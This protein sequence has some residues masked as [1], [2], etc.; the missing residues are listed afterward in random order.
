M[1]PALYDILTYNT[2]AK[3]MGIF[4]TLSQTRQRQSAFTIVELLIVIVIIGILAAITIVAYNGIQ[5]R[6]RAA[7]VQ[8]A[9]TQTVQKLAAYQL[10]NNNYPS[11]LQTIDVRDSTDPGGVSYQYHANN[12][13]TPQTYCVTATVGTTSYYLNNSTNT[14][15]TSGGCPGD[16]QGG[17]SAITNLVMNPSFEDSTTGWGVA[18]GATTSRQSVAA[19]GFGSYGVRV[20][21]GN[22][23]S[24]SGL[25]LAYGVQSGKTYTLSATIRPV[26][27]GQY[28]ISVQGSYGAVNSIDSLSS[29][30]VKRLSVTWTATGTGNSALYILK[31][32]S[33]Q[34][35]VYTFDV[36]GAMLTEGSTL[37]NYADG[38]SSNWKWNGTVNNSTSTGPIL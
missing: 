36:D 28:M 30:Q 1:Y 26:T 37:Y 32:G 31:R 13:V 23:S 19:V 11:D 29:G 38:D 5:S 34:P 21:S 7:S 18:N 25:A 14:T 16:G 17:Q 9:L 2:Q 3:E 24:D 20:T 8:A 6:A 15:P 35:G 27:A 22:N 10:D 12:A 4:V 33:G